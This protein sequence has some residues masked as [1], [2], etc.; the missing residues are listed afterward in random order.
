MS[1]FNFQLKQEIDENS[2]TASC[3]NSTI[4]STTTTVGNTLVGA[5]TE[6]SGRVGGVYNTGSNNGNG[7]GNDNFEGIGIVPVAASPTLTPP[8]PISPRESQ[9]PDGHTSVSSTGSSDTIS[10][11]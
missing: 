2:T 6:H 11:E 5:T 9:S 10:G 1:Y 8:T 4:S 3:S 7:N